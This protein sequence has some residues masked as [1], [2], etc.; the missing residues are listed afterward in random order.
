MNLKPK[1]PTSEITKS[2]DEIQVGYTYDNFL[3]YKRFGLIIFLVLIA[4]LGRF[5]GLYTFEQIET[6]ICI[7][8]IILLYI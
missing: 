4:L 6:I 1:L 2:P 5:F 7:F 3:D 8:I